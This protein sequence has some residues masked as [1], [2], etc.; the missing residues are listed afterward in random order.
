LGLRFFAARVHRVGSLAEIVDAHVRLADGAQTTRIDDLRQQQ[1]E[2]V[3][4]PIFWPFEMMSAAPIAGCRPCARL[5]PPDPGED[6]RQ[7]KMN[8]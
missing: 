5:N 1:I 3:V 2:R 7:Y 6:R 8:A 4:S